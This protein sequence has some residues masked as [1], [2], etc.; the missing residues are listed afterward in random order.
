MFVM[1]CFSFLAPIFF[2]T[3]ITTIETFDFI[4][5]VCLP[6]Y[7]FLWKEYS[8]KQ[9]LKEEDLVAGHVCGVSFYISLSY[10]NLKILI[11][12]ILTNPYFM[13]LTLIYV[14]NSIKKIK[15]PIISKLW[16]K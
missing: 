10:T 2:T 3:V 6:T 5:L 7:I 14:N 4:L 11:I 12:Q 1:V 9:K 16:T 15:N 8:I 13:E